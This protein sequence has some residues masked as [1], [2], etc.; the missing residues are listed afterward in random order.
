MIT[1]RNKFSFFALEKVFT[2]QVG[3]STGPKPVVRISEASLRHHQA[4]MYSHGAKSFPRPFHKGNILGCE[5]DVTPR[6][7]ACRLVK[8]LSETDYQSV[9]IITLVSSKPYISGVNSCT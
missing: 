7:V 9:Q 3:D 5:N 8:A 6:N 4:K 2:M 1:I